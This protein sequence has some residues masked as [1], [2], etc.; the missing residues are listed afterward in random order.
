MRGQIIKDWNK[1]NMENKADR[2]NLSQALQ[3]FASLPNKFIPPEFENSKKFKKLHGKIQEAYQAFTTTGDFPAS[4]KPIID[5][6]HALFNYDNGYEEIYDVKDFTGVKG[7]GFAMA[8][9]ESGLTF[10]KIPIGSKLELKQMSGSQEFVFFD[11]YGG[12]LNWHRSFFED[13][14]YWTLENNAQEFVNKAYYKR[15]AVFYALLEAAMDTVGCEAL[16]DPG[17]DGCDE[18]AVAVANA[19]NDAAV[20]ILEAVKD[21]GYGIN[22]GIVFKILVPL[23]LMSVVKH[24]LNNRIQQFSGAVKRVNFNFD[25]IYTMMLEN[26]NRIGVFLPKLKIKAGYR[27]NLTTFSSFDMLSLSEAAAGW[28]AFGGAV[29][30]LDQVYCIDATQ[31]SGLTG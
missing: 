27:M 23:Q 6:F 30:D 19:L 10:E 22:T 15:S 31:K 28:M 7:K 4:A 24:A 11:Y 5:K 8:N 20:H 3:F 1:F 21:K 17:C 2:D 9:I 29:G 25:P 26:H 18:Y 14:D 13:Q 12:G 16:E